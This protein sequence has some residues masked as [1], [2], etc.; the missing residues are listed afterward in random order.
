MQKIDLKKL[1]FISAKKILL[2]GSNSRQS[3][4]IKK[5]VQTI[6]SDVKKN[7]DQ[8]LV[9]YEKRFS[10]FKKLSKNN[11]VFSKSEINKIIKRLDKNTKRSINI[12]FKRIYNFH[13]NQKFKDFKI[14]SALKLLLLKK[15]TP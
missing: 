14:F 10:K 2:K 8:S 5:T 9:K 15:V 4:L 7:R 1:S 12:A 13:K 6:I 11:L 3:P